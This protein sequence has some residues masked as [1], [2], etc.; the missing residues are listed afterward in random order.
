MIGHLI[1]M[2]NEANTDLIVPNKGASGIKLG[3]TKKK[4][5]GLLG[6]HLSEVVYTLAP[7]NNTEIC[8]PQNFTEWNGAEFH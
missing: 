6:G 4:L 5:Y 2:N 8:Q 7:P 1:I 3:A